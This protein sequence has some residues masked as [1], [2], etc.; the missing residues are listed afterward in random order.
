M[1]NAECLLGASSL[2][3]VDR[4]LYRVTCRE[5]GAMRTVPRDGLRYCRNKL[6]LLRKRAEL[7]R[8]TGGALAPL[9]AGTCVL[10]ALEI[11]AYAVRGRVGR[12]EGFRLLDDCLREPSVRRALAAFPL[13]V[14]R[15][16]VALAVAFLRLWVRCR[17]I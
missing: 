7:D 3:C 13:S 4:P 15:P 16:A 14:R 5:T 17:R 11:L 9:Y 1:F 12:R 2:T 10:S 8:R 6:R